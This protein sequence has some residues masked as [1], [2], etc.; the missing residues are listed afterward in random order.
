MTK[1]FSSLPLAPKD[2]KRGLGRFQLIEA[3]SKPRGLINGN[4]PLWE[5][6][7]A[8]QCRW[9]PG[10]WIRAPS[11]SHPPRGSENV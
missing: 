3:D 1:V 2:Q 10:P 7:T 9:A 11:P 4:Y 6:A 8:N 5:C